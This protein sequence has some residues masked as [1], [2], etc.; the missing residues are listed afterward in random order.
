LIGNGWL[1]ESPRHGWPQGKWEARSKSALRK[2]MFMPVPEEL[3]GLVPQVSPAALHPAAPLQ[4]RAEPEIVP[5]RR[6]PRKDVREFP[7]YVPGGVV[8]PRA[9]AQHAQA[10]HA[11]H[12]H[13]AQKVAALQA[14]KPA[15]SWWDDPIALGTLLI[16]APPIGL[17]AVWSSKRYSSDARWALTIMTALTMCLMS[18]IVIAALA[19]R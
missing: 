19:M 13:E 5:H 11:Q 14:A 15:P 1:R 10:Q 12:L 16:L 2:C 6:D 8:D 18:A 3:R 9:V 17:A 7:A 4:K